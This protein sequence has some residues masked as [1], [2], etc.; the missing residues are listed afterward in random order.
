MVVCLDTEARRDIGRDYERQQWLVGAALFDELDPTSKRPRKTRILAFDSPASLWGTIDEFARRKGRTVVFAHNLAYDLRISDALRQLYVRGWR[1][2]HRM[3]GSQLGWLSY[4]KG[5]ST[6]WLCD[7]YSFFPTSITKIGYLMGMEKPALPSSSQDMTRLVARVFADVEILR[8]AVLRLFAWINDEGRCGF[9]ATGP[10]LAW[11]HFRRHFLPSSKV[12][13]HGQPDTWDVERRAA[14]TGR[15]E[16]WRWG[17]IDGPVY[18]WDYESAYAQVAVDVELPQSFRHETTDPSW[19]TLSRGA[20]SGRYLLR[21]IVDTEVPVVPTWSEGRVLWPVGRFSAVLWDVEAQLALEE[22]AKV[23]PLQAWFY[24]SGPLLREWGK[25]ILERI[26]GDAGTVDPVI[27]LMLK[28]WSRSLIGRFGMRYPIYEEA[29]HNERVDWRRELYLDLDLGRVSHLM[30]FGHSVYICTDTRAS[31]DYLPQV[32]SAI[33]AECR[34]RLWRAMRVAGLENVVY[35]DTDSLFVTRPGDS[36]LRQALGT[37]ELWPMRQKRYHDRLWI[38]GPRQVLSDGRPRVAGLPRGAV[39][40]SKK[41]YEA[42]VWES[43][44]VALEHGRIDS[45]LVRRRRFRL[46]G[47]DT[48]RAHLRGGATAPVELHDDHVGGKP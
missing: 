25:W 29:W 31:N 36:R 10:A 14:A 13:V 12:V 2:T 41:T 27:R 28:T 11:S 30:Q 39:R 7:S 3:V 16:A 35:C 38:G 20:S 4:R 19:R 9:K 8:D 43:F 48:R 15:C 23:V 17:H 5:N 22:G 32:M 6:L 44:P 40:L 34:V 26:H 24:R 42:E 33:M 47:R 18:E 21:C 1:S 46:R 37:G 45:V